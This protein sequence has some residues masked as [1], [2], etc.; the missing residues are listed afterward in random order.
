MLL[1]GHA[2]LLVVDDL[3]IAIEREPVLDVAPDAEDGNRLVTGSNRLKAV[4]E[5]TG[6]VGAV[7]ELNDALGG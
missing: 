6:G 5:R 3:A 4:G 7:E 2:G 1:I